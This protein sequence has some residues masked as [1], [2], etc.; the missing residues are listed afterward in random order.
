MVIDS[1]QLIQLRHILKEHENIIIIQQPFIV[2][3]VLFI[4]S[5]EENLD[6]QNRVVDQLEFHIRAP[7][8]RNDNNS[9]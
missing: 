4:D 9:K 3:H 8:E 6:H 1:C 5:Y 2:G 7:Q